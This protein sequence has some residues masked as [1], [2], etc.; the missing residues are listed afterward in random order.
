MGAD[1]LIFKR[2]NGRNIINIIP[3]MRNGCGHENC[4]I[5]V[6]MQDF[7]DVAMFLEDLRSMWNVP[8]DKAIE[9]YKKNKA[10]NAWPF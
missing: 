7:K 2:K 1:T 3:S 6:N 4:K 10:D 8:V 9:Q 5:M